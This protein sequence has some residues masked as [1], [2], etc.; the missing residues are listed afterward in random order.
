MNRSDEINRR[1]LLER[2]GLLAV[3][4]LFAERATADHRLVAVIG[5]SLGWSTALAVSGALEFDDAFRLVQGIALLQEEAA[6]R[7]I[8]GGQLI[9]PRVDVDWQ[10]VEAYAAALEAALTDGANGAQAE[11]DDAAGGPGDGGG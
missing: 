11:T 2:T 1:N 8:T 9:Y 3:G 4:A 6:E 10:P 7:G 5:N